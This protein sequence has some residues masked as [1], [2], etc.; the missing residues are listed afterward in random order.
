MLRALLRRNHA[1][2]DD[3]EMVCRRIEL[4]EQ[5]LKQLKIARV[6]TDH[7]VR[8]LSESLSCRHESIVRGLQIVRFHWDGL[9][10]SGGKPNTK[11]FRTF[12]SLETSD[13]RAA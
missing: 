4:G 13:M 5:Q 10:V 3:P 2:S 9:Q 1:R 8:L 7:R 11:L 6:S 12:K